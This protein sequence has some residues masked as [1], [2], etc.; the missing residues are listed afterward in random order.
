MNEIEISRLVE[1]LHASLQAMSGPGPSGL[2]RR[3]RFELE[4]R[5]YTADIDG[6]VDYVLA[7]IVA[8]LPNSTV[9]S[10][11]AQQI[12]LWDAISDATWAGQTLRFTPERRELICRSLKL[13]QK[14]ASA[15]LS[16]IP[17]HKGFE[18]AVLIAAEHKDWYTD[19][20]K[21][22]S[23][24][25]Y[26]DAYKNYLE[27]KAGWNEVG[28]T[29]L[30]EATDKVLK[31]IS[32][33][34]RTEAF[35][36]RGLVVGYVQSGKTANFTAVIAKSLDAGYRLVIVL[37]GVLDSLR[38]Q[39]QRRLD[40][41]LI[42]SEQILRDKEVGKPHEYSGDQ[43]W[44]KFTSY[45]M[46]PSA[47]GK[48]DIRRITTSTADYQ[49]LGQGRDVL[50]F[51]KEFKD[52]P[53]NHPD[54]LRTTAARLIV[55]KKNPA[56]IRKLIADLQGLQTSF[57]DVPAL[58]IDDESDQAS[59]NTVDP[60]K[61]ANDGEDLKL[62]TST[63][64]A[65]VDLLALLPRSQYIGYTAT[66]AANTLINPAD[67]LDL[68]PRDFIE[69]LPRPEN[70]MGVS[71]FHDFDEDFNPLSEEEV[72]ARG[73][74]SN[75]NAFV[76]FIGG[77]DDS[78]DFRAA[79]DAF[80]LTGA[81]KLFRADKD[82][83][84]VNVRHHTM[85]V[86]RSSGQYAHAED[87]DAVTLLLA[88]N[89]YRRPSAIKRL[90]RLWIEDFEPVSRAQEPALARP[91]SIEELAPFLRAAFEKFEMSRKQVLVVNGNDRFR[92]D[93][94]D[95]DKESV[96]NILIGGAKLSRGYTV[97]GLTISYFLRR[98]GAADT[99]MQMG[100]WFGF[101]RGYRDLVR[102]YI[103]T[104]V[105]AGKKTVDLYD[106]FES[107]C[108]DEE[109]FRKRIE[110][111]S[112]DG[113]K[114]IQVPPLVPMGM[115]VP[116]Q[117]NKMFNAEIAMENFGERGAESGRVTFKP[118]ARRS[119]VKVL[120]SLLDGQR[121]EPVRLTGGPR[122]EQRVLQGNS[123]KV[124][125]AAFVDFLKSYK[126]GAQGDEFTRVIGFLSGSGD[127]SPEIDC[128]RVL[129]MDQPS[130]PSKWK[131]E[132]LSCGVFRRGRTGDRFNIF[133][134]PRHKAIAKHLTGTLK[135]SSPNDELIGIS[136][137]RQAVCLVYPV[138]PKD[139]NG[140]PIVADTDV[141][142][143]LSLEFPKNS[144]PKLINWRVKDPRGSLL[145]DSNP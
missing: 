29:S 81:I 23:G 19:L 15:V 2:E 101:R 141:T 86:H 12:R 110:I 103:G 66:P 115:L 10:V 35:A 91:T 1:I 36:V 134:E 69:L 71:D 73:V 51:E 132:S 56:V 98:A 87:H 57:D 107:I 54:N 46:L 140:G 72:E 109:R 99:L 45:G 119:N 135:L 78:G 38:F 60:K 104:K 4:E 112:K 106:M 129:L 105:A 139:F 53:L 145:V 133:S 52:R 93:M 77:D 59:V 62:R 94:P 40:K 74:H 65:I 96:W 42:G 18:D 122:G 7:E 90:W 11:F 116:T 34:E 41:E 31:C 68:F 76:R 9:F 113:I 83:G 79:L 33:P 126:W 88:E 49:K 138:V 39:T 125:P 55:I 22:K 85:L 21:R 100:R 92:D 14:V 120:R 80:F 121:G 118:D 58:I 67:A 20:R 26:W 16:A 17:I 82:K 142:L 128:W 97:E 64:E 123:Y 114:P 61:P 70:Y 13:D 3:I 48:F 6:A 50:R 111:Y 32:D 24:T 127:D 117:K 124:G 108:M 137:E 95:F 44:A 144:I 89:A 136:E 102:L 84:S 5:Q 43:D 75:Q 30:N 8:G 130:A 131:F 25:F 47:L 37:A 28:T 63:N 143:G 27:Q